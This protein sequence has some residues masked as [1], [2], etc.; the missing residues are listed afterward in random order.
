[1]RSRKNRTKV[2]VEYESNMKVVGC[3]RGQQSQVANI[4][5]S[6]SLTVQL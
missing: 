1:M 2:V 4:S 6:I 3:R 5:K